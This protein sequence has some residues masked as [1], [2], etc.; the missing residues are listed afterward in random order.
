MIDLP[1]LYGP[2]HYNTKQHLWTVQAQDH[3]N[4]LGDKTRLLLLSTNKA[5][6]CDDVVVHYGHTWSVGDTLSLIRYTGHPTMQ[7]LAYYDVYPKVITQIRQE[8]DFWVAFVLESPYPFVHV[9]RIY[10]KDFG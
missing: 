1:V 6:L 4:G 8:D 3:I 5:E 2:L 9:R 10:W 7:R